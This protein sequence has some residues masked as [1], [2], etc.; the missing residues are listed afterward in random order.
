MAHETSKLV[1]ILVVGLLIVMALIAWDSAD[2]RGWWSHHRIMSSVSP[3]T[4]H[5]W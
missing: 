1:A 3:C 4:P 5:F 2:S